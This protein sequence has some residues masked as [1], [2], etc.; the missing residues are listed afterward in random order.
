MPA[1]QAP[2]VPDLAMPA[3]QRQGRWAAPTAS[4]ARNRC[5]RACRPAAADRRRACAA[6]PVRRSTGRPAVASKHPPGC[7]PRAGRHR[8]WC[9]SRARRRATDHQ[10][11]A[12]PG[13]VCGWT[14][15]RRS[16]LVRSPSCPENP[17]GPARVRRP[18]AAPGSAGRTRSGRGCPARSARRPRTAAYSTA[19]PA[20]ARNARRRAARCRHPDHRRIR[21]ASDHRMGR[22]A[23]PRHTRPPRACRGGPH[24][25]RSI[26]WSR[27]RSGPA[28]TR[29]PIGRV[30]VPSGNR[31]AA[32]SPTCWCGTRRGRV[33]VGPR[34]TRWSKRG[35][36][37]PGGRW[38]GR[39]PGGRRNR[40]SRCRMD[41][42]R[43]PRCRAAPA[44]AP[45][46]SRD[47][48]GTGWRTGS[49]PDQV[50]CLHHP[51]AP[52]AGRVPWPSRS[53]AP[54]GRHAF[55]RG[56][57]TP[58]GA[59][60]QQ[61]VTKQ[62][63]A[64]GDSL[65][66]PRCRGWRHAALCI[67]QAGI[68]PHPAPLAEPARAPRQADTAEYRAQPLAAA[69]SHVEVLKAG[70]RGRRSRGPGRARPAPPPAWPRPSP[71]A[72][73]CG[74]RCRGCRP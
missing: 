34:Q 58:F 43:R 55:A 59:V 6:G 41:L 11:A 25:D 49:G 3:A 32:G 13:R 26:R 29:M 68:V 28:R 19:K 62:A 35:W 44:T 8:A 38:A 21:P 70:W 42:I 51:R 56:G 31:Q 16:R 50:T 60:W 53:N 20:V 22:A 12:D 45:T 66:T 40:C 63:P 27:E 1:A 39:S 5:G 72:P 36:E 30:A 24:G 64:L 9:R 17:P 37:V 48:R 65:V 71:A 74:P 10:G 69:A 54:S 15:V 52:A 67:N 18:R 46:P 47:R 73:G 14:G 57:R 61:P 7:R 23:G 4:P 2:P 33:A